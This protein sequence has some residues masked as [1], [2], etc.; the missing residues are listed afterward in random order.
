MLVVVQNMDTLILLVSLAIVVI[1]WSIISR[2]EKFYFN[3][4]DDL[5]QRGFGTPLTL[6]DPPQQLMYLENAVE[7]DT[8][9]YDIIGNMKLRTQHANLIKNIN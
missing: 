5:H 8:W 7:D 9:T 3:A 4:L 6:N 1:S 2:K